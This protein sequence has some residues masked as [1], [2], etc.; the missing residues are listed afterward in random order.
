MKTVY[1]VDTVPC[2]TQM[3]TI[4]DGVDPDCIGSIFKL[5]FGQLQRGKVLEKMVFM[6]GYYLLSV[7]GTG[8]IF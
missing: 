6:D 1:K 5:I 4:L 3:R 2:D 8:Y 7:D